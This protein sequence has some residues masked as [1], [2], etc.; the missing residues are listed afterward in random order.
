MSMSVEQIM[1]IAHK[2]VQIQM[3]VILAHVLKDIC[4]I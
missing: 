4:L 2:H 1:E 3:E